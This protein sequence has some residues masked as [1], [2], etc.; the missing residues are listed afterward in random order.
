MRLSQQDHA[1]RPGAVRVA[2]PGSSLP[3]QS[4][5]VPEVDPGD[6]SDLDPQNLETLTGMGFSIAQAAQALRIHQHDVHN[7]AN[8]LL[9][10]Q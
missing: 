2:G 6:L 1:A 3:Q 5:E 10:N 4:N 7:A 9:G 8:Y